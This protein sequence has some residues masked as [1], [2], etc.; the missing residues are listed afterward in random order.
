M[1][2]LLIYPQVQSYSLSLMVNIWMGQTERH[3]GVCVMFGEACLPYSLITLGMKVLLHKQL[4][5]WETWFDDK[6][7]KLSHTEGLPYLNNRFS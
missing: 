7:E 6:V 3:K 1:F 2:F 4:L 5:N